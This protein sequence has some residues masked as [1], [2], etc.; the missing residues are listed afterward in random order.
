LSLLFS[1]MVSAGG[2]H[3]LRS[4]RHLHFGALP[5]WYHTGCP[6]QIG[7]AVPFDFDFT[8]LPLCCFEEPVGERPFYHVRREQAPRCDTQYVLTLAAPRGPPSPH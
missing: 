7:H 8:A 5:A 1:A 2:W 6:E 3:L 4:A